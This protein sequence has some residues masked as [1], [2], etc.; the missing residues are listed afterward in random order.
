MTE[1]QQEEQHDDNDNRVDDVDAKACRSPHG[2]LSLVTVVAAA[3]C[4]TVEG[5][6]PQHPQQVM[7]RTFAVVVAI[8]LT[9]WQSRSGRADGWSLLQYMRLLDYF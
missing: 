1:E 6:Q 9:K 2:V 4:R 5:E 3:Q 7:R 8:D